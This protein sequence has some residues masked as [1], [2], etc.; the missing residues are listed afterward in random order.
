MSWA[1]KAEEKRRLEK[2]MGGTSNFFIG[3]VYHNDKRGG[4]LLRAY[5]YS[6]NHTNNK[7]WWRRHANR[8][9]RRNETDILGGAL[10][11]RNFDLW[12]TLY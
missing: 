9:F 4:Y 3:P 6:T 2:L 11:K 10:H 7:K 12:W 8:K 1:S 5:P